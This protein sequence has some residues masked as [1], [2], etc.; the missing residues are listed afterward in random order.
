[1]ALQNSLNS[2]VFANVASITSGNVVVGNGS[3]PVTS[4]AQVP[5]A[6]GG[7][8]AASLTDHGVLVGSGTDPITALATGTDGQLLLGATGADPE[9]GTLGTAIG[10]GLTKTEGPGSLGLALNLSAGS[11]ITLTPSGAD[12]SI[13]I[14]A[15]AVSDLTWNAVTTGSSASAAAGNAY[16]LQTGAAYTYTLPATGVL[17]DEFVFANTTASSLFSVIPAAGGSV[18]IGATSSATGFNST[19]LGDSL[20]LVCVVAGATPVYQNVAFNGNYNVI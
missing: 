7:S 11:G 17:G 14:S 10:S 6:N 12:T 5:V 4:V 19:A 15:S 3:D 2:P 13:E 16:S 18:L 9:F 1:M 20:T 8:G